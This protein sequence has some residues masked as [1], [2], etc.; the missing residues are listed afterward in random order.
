MQMGEYILYYVQYK[1]SAERINGEDNAR[2]LH[3][4]IKITL[5]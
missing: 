5:F 3:L 2:T 4:N 1:W